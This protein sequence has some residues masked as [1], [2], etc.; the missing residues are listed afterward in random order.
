MFESQM[1]MILITALGC[2]SFVHFSD[3]VV[4]VDVD[5]D[6]SSTEHGFYKI[7]LVRYNKKYLA[8]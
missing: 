4:C 7:Q 6:G 8:W 5:G 1:L 3:D 2:S